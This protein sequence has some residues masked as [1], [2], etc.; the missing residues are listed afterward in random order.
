MTA[1]GNPEACRSTLR[2]P[3]AAPTTSEGRPFREHVRDGDGGRS[4]D[5]RGDSHAGCPPERPETRR[6]LSPA[7]QPQGASGRLG[8]TRQRA[9]AGSGNQKK[10][11]DIEAQE[12]RG[13]NSMA[14]KASSEVTG[15]ARGVPVPCSADR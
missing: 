11:V 13:R 4:C 9:K 6:Q 15:P 1:S 8:K 3:M 5:R 12:A 10:A 14:E 7:W 2:P